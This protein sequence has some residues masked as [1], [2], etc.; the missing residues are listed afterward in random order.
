ML[1]SLQLL[2]LFA[3]VLVYHLG[4]LRR[5][6]ASKA[7]APAAEAYPVLVIDPG[8][9]DFAE[10]AR[11]ALNRQAGRVRVAVMPELG[12]F[13]AAEGFAAVILP[14]SVALHPPEGLRGWLQGYAGRRI[15]IPD[16]AGGSLLAGDA[17]EAAH[18]ARR[19]A[20]G[21]EVTSVR[22]GQPGWM[23]FVYI[24]AALFILQLLLG[25]LAFGISSL[26]RF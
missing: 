20:D 9:G 5:D 7:E 10:Q 22:A 26:V 25:L 16:E 2:A 19:L 6:G 15:I 18:L 21:Q 1:N 17:R 12:D 24:C 23:I 14:E 3:V 4:A 13:S 8:R 11:V